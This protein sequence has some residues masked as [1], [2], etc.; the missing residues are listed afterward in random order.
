MFAQMLKLINHSRIINHDEMKEFRRRNWFIHMIR[1]G[2]AGQGVLG[3]C[4]DLL[5]NTLLWLHFSFPSSYS[6]PG[7]MV[8][9][10]TVTP[11][12]SVLSENT[13]LSRIANYLWRACP[14]QAGGKWRLR[15]GTTA[16]TWWMEQW[17]VHCENVWEEQLHLLETSNEY[18][19]KYCDKAALLVS[20]FLLITKHIQ[21]MFFVSRD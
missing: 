11:T 18:F 3:V 12:L 14:C 6:G 1:E 7:A 10:D 15:R 19:V 2:G 5:I 16:S 20:S 4:S 21:H 9:W 8:E 17:R 13:S